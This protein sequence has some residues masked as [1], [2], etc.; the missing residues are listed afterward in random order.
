MLLGDVLNSYTTGTINVE[1][2]STIRTGGIAGR[3]QG[4]STLNKVY[5]EASINVLAGINGSATNYAYVGGLAGEANGVVSNSYNLGSVISK[6]IDATNA[7]NVGGVIGR[8]WYTTADFTNIY[9]SGTV[10]ID[11]SN[12]G[13]AG[14]AGSLVGVLGD[15]VELMYSY[16]NTTVANVGTNG[17]GT[18]TGTIA[19]VSGKTTAE[20]QAQGTFTPGTGNFDFTTVWIM[21]SISQANSYPVL[22]GVGNTVITASASANGT[23]S[24]VG[25][26]L[27]TS[28]ASRAFT[29]TPDSGY[30]IEDVLVDGATE[31]AIGSYTFTNARGTHTISASFIVITYV[32][33]YN[34]NGGTNHNANPYDYTIEFVRTSEFTFGTPTKTGYNF[35]GWFNNVGL[36]TAQSTIPQLSTGAITVWAKWSLTPYYLEFNANG[37][38]GSMADQEVNFAIAENIN[39]NNNAFTRTGYTFDG[40]DTIDDG[41]YGTYADGASFTLISETNVDLYVQWLAN[42]HALTLEAESGLIAANASW[43]GSGATATKTVTYDS[44]VGTLPTSAEITRTGYTFSGWFTEAGGL[45]IQITSATAYNYQ[46]SDETLYA[47]WV[48]KQIGVSITHDTD[49]VGDTGLSTAGSSANTNYNVGD[50]ITLNATIDNGYVFDGWNKTTGNNEASNGSITSPSS[51]A[52]TY[53]ITPQDAEDGVALAFVA[54]AHEEVYIVTYYLDGGTNHLS[55]PATYKITE[56]PI[57]LNNATKLGYDFVGWYTEGTFVNKVTEIA[58]GAY[59]DTDLYAKW[60]PK[61]ARIEIIIGT[62][63]SDNGSTVVGLGNYDVDTEIDLKAVANLN[64]EFANWTKVNGTVSIGDAN[65]ATTTYIISAQD[66]EDYESDSRVIRFTANFTL[67]TNPVTFYTTTDGKSWVEHLTNFLFRF[68]SFKFWTR[69]TV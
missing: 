23:I 18:A 46:D 65:S 26:L 7:Q 35:E 31:G 38:S 11:T 64:Y 9:N 3:A 63:G 67:N 47:Y 19:G 49:T 69:L 60:T 28:A 58:T 6:N 50:I 32:V 16:Y 27:Y 21:D 25:T 33:T 51:L 54:T 14:Y 39:S 22:R 1:A 24:P 13:L 56:T 48:S 5:N 34:M 10:T 43:T 61:Q 17:V 30:E 37:G 2:N 59:S 36:T 15:D 4:T 68:S 52:T 12:G 55:N 41:D 40:W 20:M 66:A 57:T 42:S 8:S 45:G 53:T 62:G 29:I 44:A